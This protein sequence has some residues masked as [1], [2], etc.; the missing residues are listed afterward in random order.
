MSYDGKANRDIPA[1]QRRDALPV[2]QARGEGPQSGGGHQ[3]RAN[4]GPET[5]SADIGSSQRPVRLG[6]DPAGRLTRQILQLLPDAQLRPILSD[7]TSWA[8]AT[9]AGA[10]HLI[11]LERGAQGCF[12]T[13]EYK[14]IEA[15]KDHEFSIARHLVADLAAEI[16]VDGERQLLRIEAL[17]VEVG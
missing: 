8:S 13:E 6:Q 15:L 9:F 7:S 12:S 11:L 10:R 2:R 3:A 17:T 1:Q 4:G 14:V 16:L 5:A